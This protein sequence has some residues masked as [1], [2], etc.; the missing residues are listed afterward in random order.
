MSRNKA[1]Q[2]IVTDDKGQEQ[3]SDKDRAQ[4]AGKGELDRVPKESD[5]D[6]EMQPTREKSGF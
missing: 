2:G 6:D 1:G 4:T 3:P 5:K